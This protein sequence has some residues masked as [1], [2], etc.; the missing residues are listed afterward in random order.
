MKVA[1]TTLQFRRY[2]GMASGCRG[3]W[4][5]TASPLATARHLCNLIGPKCVVV[6]RHGTAQSCA[7]SGGC[8]G[9]PVSIGDVACRKRS[10]SSGVSS[11]SKRAKS[12]ARCFVLDDF[13]MTGIPCCTSHLNATCAPVLPCARPMDVTRSPLMRAVLSGGGHGPHSEE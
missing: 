11:K 13:G 4:H 8:G 12:S 5:A 1:L 10:I 9:V 2:F 3:R 6:T 7:S